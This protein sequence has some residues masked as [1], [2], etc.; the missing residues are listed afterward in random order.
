MFATLLG[1]IL[2]TAWP[3]PSIDRLLRAVLLEDRSAAA[4]AWREF[5]ASADFD[6][7]TAGEMQLLGLVSKHL[8]TFAPDSRLRGRIGGIGR[9]NWSRSQLVIGEAGGGLRA[10]AAEGVAVLAIGGAGHVA[11]GGVAARGRAV[12]GVDVVVRPDDMQRALDLLTEDGWRRTGPEA[13]MP[14]RTQLAEGGAVGVTLARGQFGRLGLHRT[15]FRPPHASAAD[16]AA[17]W[18]RST[19]GTLAYAAV[20]LPAAIDVVTMALAQ[21][22]SRGRRGGDWLA[23]IAAGIDRGVDWDLFESVTDRRRLHAPGA[24]ALRYV[25]ER[26]ERPVPDPVLRRL[27]KAAF[28]DPLA[29]GGVLARSRPQAGAIG[30]L[31]RAAA[32]GSR[33]PGSRRHTVL[34]SLAQRDTGMESG[35]KTLE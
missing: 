6:H 14:Q 17:I 26:L 10:F 13:A 16:D 30:R 8:E 5:E 34:P 27:E 28:R 24:V 31:V 11:A 25:H 9:A 22:L 4:V 33:R 7:P 15:A 1:A 23:D 32:M 21:G 20:R 2:R 3:E 35:A 29:L 18:Q 12:N 19:P